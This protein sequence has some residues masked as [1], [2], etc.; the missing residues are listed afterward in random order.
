MKRVS[1]AV[2]IAVGF[3]ASLWVDAALASSQECIRWIDRTPPPGTLTNSWLMY[4]T[5]RQATLLAAESGQGT[6]SW[7]G[8]RFA[9]IG[10][11]IVGNPHGGVQA[12]AFDARRG[13]G[14][15]YSRDAE[16]CEW[17]G[18]SWIQRCVAD[19]GPREF[20]ALAYDSRRGVV[21]L[22]GGHS[23]QEQQFLADTWEW[24]GQT[25][26]LKA[27]GGPPPR[28]SHALAYDS[29]R[30]VTV[31]FGGYAG[32]SVVFG[33]TWEW[34]GSNWTLRDNSGP[35]RSSPLMTYDSV[36][37]VTLVTGGS[38]DPTETWGW[39]GTSWALLAVGGPTP[40]SAYSRNALTFDADRGVAV[41]LT[42]TTGTT[43]WEWNG[44]EWQ[45]RYANRLSGFSA[46]DSARGV[47]VTLADMTYE[48]GG[49]R[50]T[51][52]G[53]GLPVLRLQTAMAFDERRGVCVLFGGLRD[54]PLGDT[55]E[56][57]GSEWSLRATTG[58]PPRHSHAMAYDAARGVTVLYAGG[59]ATVPNVIGDTW[60]WDG[61]TWTQRTE[62][63]P[64]AR[65]W[66]AMT[67]DTARQVTVCVGGSVGP[68]QTEPYRTHE[69]TGAHWRTLLLNEQPATWVQAM[70][71][72][73]GERDCLAVNF[74]GVGGLWLMRFDGAI[75]ET[76]GAAP[77]GADFL[78][79]DSLCD[80]TYC[81]ATYRVFELAPGGP[82]VTQYPISQRVCP[83][84]SAW[85]WVAAE[86][87]WPFSYQWQKDGVPL[88]DGP[89]VQ[90]AT[91]AGLTILQATGDDA[92]EYQ[93]VVTDACGTTVG[94]ASVLIVEG[95]PCDVNCDGAVD[96]FDIDP[97][98]ERLAGCYPACSSCA[99]DVDG[100][101]YVT[102]FDIDGLLTAILGGGCP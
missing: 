12:V 32:G 100:D 42:N 77:A 55:W 22:F 57:N 46:F 93:V 59:I 4:D 97:F 64:P 21:V 38:E 5:T 92:G 40:E 1:L 37:H 19:P 79:Y 75:W 24:D 70:T 28:E 89:N 66:H 48:W 33:D 47:V 54:T 96:G 49:E 91:D 61:S 51:L 87:R 9:R 95:N 8:S 60:E 69:W 6:W 94:A 10:D 7:D 90:G 101:G 44:V 65:A 98:L 50:W 39:D 80:R 34:D 16:T 73:S 30:G 3:A 74:N 31:L 52:R 62:P 41:L 25:W 13:V 53:P 102:G 85:F 36:R 67:Y 26:E 27:T 17:N 2:A 99:G 45:W 58:P 81:L 18:V 83:G 43:I 14:V 78:W 11:G 88:V 23:Q 15:Y 76:L 86:G 72:R 56:W 20:T 29:D 71:Y 84:R 63:A 35:T 68:N 82:D